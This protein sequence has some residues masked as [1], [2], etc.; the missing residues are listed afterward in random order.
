[1]TKKYKIIAEKKKPFTSSEGE[2]INYYWTKAVRLDDEMEIEFG[3]TVGGRELG[4]VHDLFV[5]K[6][7]KAN[8]KFGYREQVDNNPNL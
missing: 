6:Y 8:G 2:Q 3:T 4:S 1:M 7:E 5:T